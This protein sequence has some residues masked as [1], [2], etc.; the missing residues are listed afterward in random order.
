MSRFHPMERDTHITPREGSI[1]SMSVASGTLSVAEKLADADSAVVASGEK[2]STAK[3]PPRFAPELVAAV[4]FARFT[5][6]GRNPSL[7][8]DQRPPAASAGDHAAIRARVSGMI[9]GPVT[10]QAIVKFSG[11]GSLA[12]LRRVAEFAPESKDDL[13][14]LKSLGSAFSKDTNKSWRQG[15]FLAGVLVAWSVELSASKPKA[16]RARRRR[17]RWRRGPG[18]EAFCLAGGFRDEGFC[19]AGG[20]WGEGFW[21]GRVLEGMNLV[22]TAVALPRPKLIGTAGSKRSP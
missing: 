21:N 15:R 4:K 13:A 18:G 1:A 20:S 12:A 19:L 22:G 16:A 14:K 2:K 17:T 9:E 11:V 3:S 6:H 5:L 10:P 8:K 7:K